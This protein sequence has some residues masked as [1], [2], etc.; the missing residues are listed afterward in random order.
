LVVRL[1]T[2]GLWL[3]YSYAPLSGSDVEKKSDPDFSDIEL[4]LYFEGSGA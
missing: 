4:D 2:E 3:S 1:L